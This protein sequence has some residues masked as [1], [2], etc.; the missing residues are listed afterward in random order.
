MGMWCLSQPGVEPVPPALEGKF[1]TGEVPVLQAL[2]A[3]KT[4][5]PWLSLDIRLF[6]NHTSI[7]ERNNKKVFLIITRWK[8]CKEPALAR[9]FL[10]Q[11]QG[12]NTRKCY[13]SIYHQWC[14]FLGGVG[15]RKGTLL[16][17]GPRLLLSVTPSCP[18]DSRPFLNPPQL[19]AKGGRGARAYPGNGVHRLHLHG[20][21]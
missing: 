7:P 20:V 17:S 1:S 5:W 6:A 15:E 11:S 10:P 9:A 8:P 21:G 3:W 2:T 13:F 18:R 14:G 16:H 19:A 12:L 4:T